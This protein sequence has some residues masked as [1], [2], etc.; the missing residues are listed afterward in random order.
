MGTVKLILTD[1]GILISISDATLRFSLLIINRPLWA[2][3][4]KIRENACIFVAPDISRATK[5]Q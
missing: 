2:C 3:K 1:A 5:C 4:E